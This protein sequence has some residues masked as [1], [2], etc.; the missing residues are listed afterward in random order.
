M[1][2]QIRVQRNGERRF[3]LCYTLEAIYGSFCHSL[4]LRQGAK[5]VSHGFK[6]NV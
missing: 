4:H 6:T 1:K 5:E 3:L 2:L